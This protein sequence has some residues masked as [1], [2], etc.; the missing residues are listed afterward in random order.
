MFHLFGRSGHPEDPKSI[1]LSEVSA[2]EMLKE[3]FVCEWMTKVSANGRYPST[4]GVH[5]NEQRSH[6]IS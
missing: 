2:Y 1:L 3:V 6:C 4:R 5:C